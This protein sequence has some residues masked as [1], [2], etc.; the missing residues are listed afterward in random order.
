M[1]Y[2]Q[3]TNGYR[4]NEEKFLE[5]KPLFTSYPGVVARDSYFH[6]MK[7]GTFFVCEGGGLPQGSTY[8][9]TVVRTEKK[10]YLFHSD[11]IV[12]V[13]TSEV[14]VQ[15]H[16]IPAPM[17]ENW[18]QL[19]LDIG[20]ENFAL[21]HH[22]YLHLVIDEFWKHIFGKTTSEMWCGGIIG[23]HGDKAYGYRD[24]WKKADIPFGRGVLLYLLTYT[25]ELG[26]TPKHKSCEWV[27]NNYK[28]YL[29]HIESAE[30]LAGLT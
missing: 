7:P 23:A 25:K 3:L 4:L 5:I 15:A 12:V 28:K 13:E 29:P 24:Q 18:K 2:F 21:N 26:D 30:K 27:I 19:F 1:S 8:W 6:Q 9:I 14:G 20:A 17:E 22:D 10:M 16:Y 11:M